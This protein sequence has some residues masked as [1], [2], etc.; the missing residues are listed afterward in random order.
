MHRINATNFQFKIKEKFSQVSTQGQ[1]GVPTFSVKFSNS[2]ANAISFHIT[3]SQ[4]KALC[5]VKRA[6]YST[7][8]VLSVSQRFPLLSK[9]KQPI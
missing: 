8:T 9:G 6:I 5:Y 2:R 3:K 1:L 7:T 4:F